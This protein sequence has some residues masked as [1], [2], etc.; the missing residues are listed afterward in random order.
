MARNN[1]PSLLVK[2]LVLFAVGVAAGGAGFYF[3]FRGGPEKAEGPAIRP[4]KTM[5]KVT[6]LGRLEPA[7]GV[8]TLGIPVPDRV[9]EIYKGVHEEAHVKKN[10]PLV[11]LESYL[12]RE[13]ELKSI[14]QQ[15]A[16]AREKVASLNRKGQA[17]I[18]LDRLRIQQLKE[19][20]P[21]DEKMQ[22]GQRDLLEQQLKAARENL[23][24]IKALGN[25]ISPQD[26]EEQ[27]LR[28]AQLEI[29]VAGAVNSLRRLQKAGELDLLAAN[30][31]L[32]ASKAALAS[33]LKEVSLEA[34]ESQK[35][36][37]EIRLDQ[38]V[39]WAPREGTILK[40]LA[41]SGELVGVGQPI[42][43]MGDTT[44][45]VAVAEVYETDI[46]RV[47]KGSQAVITGR[48]LEGELKGEVVQIGAMVGK[49]R[50]YDVDP[51]AEVDHRVVEVRILLKE[52]D[53]VAGLINH[54]VKVEIAPAAV[55]GQ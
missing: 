25:T 18:E 40:V 49:N 19:L 2:G 21:L 29:K 13:L 12:A 52:S 20:G 15:L 54:Q 4:A 7:T 35:H 36:L 6:A 9:L 55:S 41:R 46:H 14:I 50:V 34:L 23:T 44:Q 32:A 37:A 5:T 39:L 11:K 53:K 16:D 26:R 3:L 43:Q 8:R 33:A 48:A 22:I 47:R 17:Q 51:T 27:E 30:A 1:D 42:L 31:Q 24:R 45:M 28:V 10:Q 38:A